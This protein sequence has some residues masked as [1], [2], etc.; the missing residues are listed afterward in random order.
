MCL[1]ASMASI[2]ESVPLVE[3]ARLRVQASDSPLVALTACERR[4]LLAKGL[5]GLVCCGSMALSQGIWLRTR[6]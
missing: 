6:D 1:Q 3:D 5:L 4:L 2:H